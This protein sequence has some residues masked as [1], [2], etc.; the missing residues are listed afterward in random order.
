[1]CIKRMRA[2]T[3]VELLVVIG[4]IALLI[5][6]LL[7][8]LQ[9]AR[10]QAK[11]TQDLSNIRQVAIA[12]VGYAAENHGDWPLGSKLGPNLGGWPLAS[13]GGDDLLFVNSYTF[14]YF[15]QYM[16]NPGTAQTWMNA[17]FPPTGGQAAT[18]PLDFN[19]KRRFGCTSFIDATTDNNLYATD[20]GDIGRVLPQTA[21]TDPNGVG[22]NPTYMGFDYWGRR[23]NELRGYIYD[24]IGTQV[25]PATVF[26]FPMKQGIRS[27]S[28]TLL[29]CPAFTVSSSQGGHSH[30][31]HSGRNDAFTIYAGTSGSSPGNGRGSDPSSVM[32]G[33]C[34]AYTDGSAQWVPHG[35]L[36]SMFE[37]SAGGYQPGFRWDYF[38]GNQH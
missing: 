35:R 12:C 33:I 21:Q 34:C 28:Q 18:N 5:A 3:L 17:V 23:Q 20:L 25:T 22:Y 8:A 14:G 24:Q 26:N 32:N 30:W 16:T 7:P 15:L 37:A 4:I 6:I 2:F 13:A 10:M 29:T 1:M 31:P 9:K 27:S 19:I 11:R 36:W 38:D